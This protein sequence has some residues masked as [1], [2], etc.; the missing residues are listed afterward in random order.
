M[1]EIV[2]WANDKS[3]KLVI[4]MLRVIKILVL[5]RTFILANDT[6]NRIFRRNGP[7][8]KVYQYWCYDVD[9]RLNREMKSSIKE[10]IVLLF[11]YCYSP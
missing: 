9:K 8:A 7:K 1:L 6:R 3:Y 10:N 11:S 4:Y 5:K 2:N